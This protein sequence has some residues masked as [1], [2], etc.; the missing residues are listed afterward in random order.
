MYSC[1]GKQNN[2]EEIE[3]TK[4]NKVMFPKYLFQ[5]AQTLIKVI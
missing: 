5:G 1:F 4:L 2:L 3:D